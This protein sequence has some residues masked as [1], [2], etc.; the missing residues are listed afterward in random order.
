MPQGLLPLEQALLFYRDKA[1]VLRG[2]WKNI[3][4]LSEKIVDTV[5]EKCA[6]MKIQQMYLYPT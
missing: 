6:I 4:R 1:A 3:E 2:I 5:L